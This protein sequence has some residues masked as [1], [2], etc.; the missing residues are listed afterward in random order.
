MTQIYSQE[1]GRYQ[2]DS[3]YTKFLQ[4]RAP[5]L[6]GQKYQPI[7]LSIE[8]RKCGFGI[9]NEVKSNFDNFTFE[10]RQ[11]LKQILYR[12]PDMQKSIISPSG[13]FR[14]HFDTTN[15]NGNGIPSYVP[16]WSIDQNVSEVAKALDSAYNFEV[17]YIGFLPPPSDDVAGGDYRYDIY[18]INQSSQ[19]YGY[20]EW[21]NKV[22]PVNWTSFMV[23]DNDYSGYYSPGLDGMKVTVA[24]EFH[25]GIQVGS[26]AIY[27]ANSPVRSADTFFYELTST[28]M[29]EFVYDDVNDYYSYM[30]SYFNST[31]K[32]FSDP[33]HSGYDM[34]I[35]NIYLVKIYDF[36][37]L[38]KQW[39]LMPTQRAMYAISNS[40]LDRNSN[41]AHDY[42]RF[43]IW[44]YYT[45]YRSIP[46][47]PYF[48]EAENYPLIKPQSK[49][50]YPQYTYANVYA[51]AASN[52]FIQ[53]GNTTNGDTLYA[54][55]T[56]GDVSS[57]I[58]DSSQTFP[59]TY[60]LFSDT[61]SGQRVLGDRYSANFEVAN[62]VWW[63]VS[64]ILNN[65]L[66]REDS[67]QNSIIED[68]EIFIF[69]NPCFY[70]K[71]PEGGISIS[72][73]TKVGEEADLNVYSVGMQLLFSSVLKTNPI[74]TSDGKTFTGINWDGL[75]NNKNKLKSGVY[76]CVIKIG[77]DILKGK[78]VIFNE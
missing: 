45:G 7:P 24:H 38:K 50:S 15:F 32:S 14:V 56:N 69:P 54:I 42:N 55:V 46:N 27:D 16:G 17:N 67:T 31:Y 78:V 76:I 61:L 34:A 3:L 19:V 4:I 26:Y 1:L 11:I 28:S 33:T 41:F 29:E 12:P 5:E 68:K 66:V 77:E 39:E 35:W 52:N 64:E 48:K 21:E 36:Q 47:S 18:I 13:F 22:G 59:F 57:L 30:H 40:I 60:T 74:I 53:F 71:I 20:T 6:L 58:N 23:I 25:H 75:D 63:S 2:L 8:D 51:Y 43:G 65:I 44:T 73:K 10:Q 9:V 37:I 70:S 72:F 62:P 49:I